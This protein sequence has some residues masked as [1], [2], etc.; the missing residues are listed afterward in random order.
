MFVEPERNMG[1]EVQLGAAK[2]LHA[3]SICI[4]TMPLIR[5]EK[6][7]PSQLFLASMSAWNRQLNGQRSKSWTEKNGRG[8]RSHPSDTKLLC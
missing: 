7:K 1:R 5:N 4:N 3:F 8:T 2:A 6:K